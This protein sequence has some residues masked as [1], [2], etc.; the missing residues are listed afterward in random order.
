MGWLPEEETKG[1]RED[2]NPFTSQIEISEKANQSEKHQNDLNVFFM[3]FVFLGRLSLLL[4]TADF[5]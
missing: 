4:W 2:S 5:V 1:K 3:N